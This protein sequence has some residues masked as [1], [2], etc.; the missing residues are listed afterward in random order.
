M[1]YEKKDGDIVMNTNTK[2]GEHSHYGKY[3]HKGEDYTFN[4]FREEQ[5]VGKRPTHRSKA[6]FNG[7]EANISL[8]IGEA[9]EGSKKPSVTG[10]MEFSDWKYPVA[11]W[12]RQGSYGVFWSGKT[13]LGEERRTK[14]FKP[15][16]NGQSRPDNKTAKTPVLDDDLDDSIPFN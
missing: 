14:S 1:A 12:E 8:W 3:R 9:E 4:I 6:D 2:D 13:D 15:S 7:D 10:Y 16:G 5:I 11:L